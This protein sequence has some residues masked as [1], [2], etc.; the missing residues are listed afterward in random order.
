M[1]IINKNKTAIVNAIVVLY[2]K[3]IYSSNNYKHTNFI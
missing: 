2:N 3:K 1:G